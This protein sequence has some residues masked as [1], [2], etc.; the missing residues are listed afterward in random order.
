[1][2]STA[3]RTKRTLCNNSSMFLMFL[4]RAHYAAK[5]FPSP[6][7]ERVLVVNKACPPRFGVLRWKTPELP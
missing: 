4:G 6:L 1:M 2:E 3:L 5:K 7:L